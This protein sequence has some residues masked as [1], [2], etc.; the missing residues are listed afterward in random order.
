MMI[1]LDPSGALQQ[2]SGELEG[3]TLYIVRGQNRILGIQDVLAN[4]S[5]HC[6]QM[7]AMDDLAYFLS[8]PGALKRVP[9][10]IL[11]S[12]SEGLNLSRLT[13]DDLVGIALLYRYSVLGIG[14]RIFTSNDRSGRGTLVAPS[15]LRARVADTV[16]RQLVQRGAFAVLLSYTDNDSS[17][18][19]AKTTNDDASG[20]RV[21]Y[22]TEE[23]K[24]ERCVRMEKSIQSYLPLEET[25]DKT[26]A[27]IGQRSRSNLRYYR[28][29]AEN[30][31]G[32][33]FL[34]AVEIGRA[35]YLAFNR[36]CMYRV[37]DR[38][39]KWRYHSFKTLS[40]P[41][42]VGIKDGNGR[43]L[44]LLGARR[45]AKT[46]EILW[47]MNRAGLPAYSLSIVMRSY[48]I[49]HE[50]A[51]GMV[52]LYIEGG[53]GHPI[54]YSFVRERTTGI[55]MMRR[56]FLASMVPC[57]ARP[58]IKEDNDLAGLLLHESLY[59]RIETNASR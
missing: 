27:N 54:G 5:V 40:S 36:E 24:T 30:K 34:S 25:F 56:S 48:F 4:F 16:C 3:T 11:L 31:L 43:W 6:G 59:G 35:E 53:T 20:P 49:E 1:S 33:F 50:I 9:Y 18:A 58:F 22:V 32:C 47:Q 21:S 46:T 28:R 37:S 55:A 10:L 8:K 12:H 13:P 45:R 39:A 29:R 42:L 57:V 2:D 44:S 51:Q 7:G 52:R 17:P 38:V 15:A 23:S 41:V 14:I 26:L 19:R